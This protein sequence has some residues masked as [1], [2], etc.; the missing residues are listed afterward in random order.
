MQRV[1]GGR[2]VADGRNP[3]PRDLISAAT[4]LPAGKVAAGRDQITEDYDWWGAPLASHAPPRIPTRRVVNGG[5]CEAA[6]ERSAPP[7]LPTP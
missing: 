4:C 3:P 6:V 5:G 7:P 1:A 2:K